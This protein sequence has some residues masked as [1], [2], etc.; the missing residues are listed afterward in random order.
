MNIKQS[1]AIANIFELPF[2]L[3]FEELF[4]PLLSTK[5]LLIERIISTGQTTPSGEW[6]DQERDEW[7]ILLQGEAQLTYETGATYKLIPGGYLLIPAHQR[8]RVD[9]TSSN[10]PCI[11]LAIHGHLSPSAN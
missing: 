6:Y 3:P 11:W 5:D 1:K 4:E 10:P 7:V 2:Q 9:Y 8:H